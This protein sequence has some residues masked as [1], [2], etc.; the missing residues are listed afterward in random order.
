MRDLGVQRFRPE[1]PHAGPLLRPALRQDQLRAVLEPEPERGCLRP[2][3]S[4]AQVLEAAG[5]HQVHDEEEL[6]VFRRQDQPLAAPARAKEPL[7][8]EDGERRIERLQRR[9]V[10]RAGLC[11]RERPHRLVERAA[12]RL[13]LGQLRHLGSL[14]TWTRSA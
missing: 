13:H 11:D 12:K 3:L 5:A 9:D 6:L 7:A 4:R 14:S 1:E 2:L 8:L 10:P